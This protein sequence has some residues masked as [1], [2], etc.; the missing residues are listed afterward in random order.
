MADKLQVT[1]IGLGLIGASAG[2]ALR[3]Y[4]EK[5][6]VVGH[7]RDSGLAGKAKRAGAVNQTEWNLINAAA[8]ADRILLALP[9]GEVQ[10][11]LAAIAG[12]LKPGCVLVDTADVKVPVIKWA[13]ELLPKE[14]H[15][16]GGHPILVSQQGAQEEATAGLF[17]NKLFCLT[18]GAQTDDT[19]VRLAADLATALGAR[20][21]FLD[22]TEH[23]GLIAA[24]E[25]LPQ[26][27]AGAL[28]AAA[29]NSTGWRD[30]RKLAGGQFYTG[31]QLAANDGQ[32]AIGACAANRQHTLFWLDQLIGELGAWRQRLADGDDQSLAAAIDGGLSLRE[33]WLRAQIS[34]DWGDEIPGPPIP[35]AGTMMRDVLGFGPRRTPPVEK[36]KR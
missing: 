6:H 1:I 13:S 22:A 9:I 16:V 26:L 20:P 5:V 7:D 2:L 4:G 33:E 35:T 27:V 10:E 12:E 31:T 3:Q 17:Q 34:G 11:T 19:A 14:A 30:M 8:N 36:G 21:F 24:V 15:L 18:P 28:L 25:H 32:A 29:V 23:D